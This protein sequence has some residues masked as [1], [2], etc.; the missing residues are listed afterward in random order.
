MILKSG[1]PFLEKIMIKQDRQQ[2][3]LKQSG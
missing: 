1:H 2:I 3:F